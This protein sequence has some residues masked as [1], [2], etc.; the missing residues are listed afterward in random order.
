[1]KKTFLI[2]TAFICF[3]TLAVAF[4]QAPPGYKNLQILPKDISERSLD[5]VMHNYSKSLGVNCGFCH[6]HNELR[7]TWD[8]ASDIKPEKQIARK[9]MLME[10]GINTKYFPNEDGDKNQPLIQA[11]TCYTCHKGEAM[12]VSGPEMKM[13]SLNKR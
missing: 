3:I 6:L 8:M 10:K 4:T 5:S 9:M 11:V 1:M 12:P 7:D 13:D 2:V